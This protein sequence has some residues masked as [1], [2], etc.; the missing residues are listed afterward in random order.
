[1]NYLSTRGLAPQFRFSEILLGGL[2]SDGGL[3]MPE[4]YP[5][6]SEVELAE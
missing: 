4:N 5:R 2:A 1:M 3:Y 6:F